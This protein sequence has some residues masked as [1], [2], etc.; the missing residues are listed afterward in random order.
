[1]DQNWVEGEKTHSPFSTHSQRKYNRAWSV[2]IL[3]ELYVTT[4]FHSFAFDFFVYIAAV[5]SF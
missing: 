2:N 4:H 5:Y 3:L 1:M